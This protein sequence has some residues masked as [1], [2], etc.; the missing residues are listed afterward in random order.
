MYRFNE[1]GARTP[2]KSWG[3]RGSLA[4][5]LAHRFNEAGARTPRKSSFRDLFAKTDTKELQ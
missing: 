2:R 4:G 1:A 3:R 5:S